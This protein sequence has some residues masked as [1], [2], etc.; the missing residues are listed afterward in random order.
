MKI[1]AKWNSQGDSNMAVL[2]IQLLTGYE[3]HLES[4]EK[5]RFK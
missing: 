4:L 5:V 2:E 1:C 3:P